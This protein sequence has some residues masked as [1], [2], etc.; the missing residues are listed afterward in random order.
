MPIGVKGVSPPSCPPTT[1][2]A[3][4]TAERTSQIRVDFRSAIARSLPLRSGRTPAAA[5]LIYFVRIVTFLRNCAL[6][7]PAGFLVAA[8]V[9]LISHGPQDPGL[10]VLPFVGEWIGADRLPKSPEI[11]FFVQS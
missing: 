6:L 7:L 5:L 9:F 3:T 10:A 4:A 2:M 8:F 1:I 11:S